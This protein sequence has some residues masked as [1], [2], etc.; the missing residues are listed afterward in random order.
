MIPATAFE[1]F[2]DV[3]HACVPDGHSVDM[4]HD[5]RLLT[6][7]RGLCGDHSIVVPTRQ[8]LCPVCAGKL[9][10]LEEIARLRAF[11]LQHVLVAQPAHAIQSAVAEF[12]AGVEGI[13]S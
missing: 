11:A 3:I 12:W 9:H 10:D 5:R 8:G 6:S 13:M 7:E 2:A 1:A 4:H